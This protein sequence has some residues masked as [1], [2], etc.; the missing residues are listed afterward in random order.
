MDG[1]GQELRRDEFWAVD[2]VSF[3][4]KR[5]ECLGL[6]G[7]NGAGK[8]TLLKMLN[9]LIKP[10]RGRIEIAGRVGA[11]IALGAGFNPILTGRENVYVNG[12]ILGLSKRE[13][14]LRFNEIIAFAELEDFIDTPVQSYSSGMQVRL[15]FAVAAVLIKPDVLLLDEVLAVGDVG[16]AIKCLNTIKSLMDKSAV[17]FVSHNMQFVSAFCDRIAVMEK[18]EI[19][20]DSGNIAHGIDD[21]LS[22]FTIYESTAGSGEA[23]IESVILTCLQTRQTAAKGLCI[24]FGSEIRLEASVHT[25]KHGQFWVQIDTAGLV[26]V[27]AVQV[28]DLDSNPLILPPGQHN[29][30]LNLGT[31]E[32]NSGIYSLALGLFDPITKRSLCR[33]SG[34]ADFRVVSD[35]VEW[36]HIIRRSIARIESVRAK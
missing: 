13:I 21:Y 33:Q 15:G 16:F 28:K 5:G 4:L 30:Q 24:P 23:T 36:G 32:L 11:L 22:L 12:S 27:V 7:R 29:V 20:C 6:I 1:E 2:N 17:V 26:P 35:S 25:E 14:D 18:G 3:E 9:G 19:R 10:D 34:M 8:T 31:V